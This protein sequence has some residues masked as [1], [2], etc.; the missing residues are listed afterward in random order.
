MALQEP[1]FLILTS[2]A[3][4]RKHGYALI[5]DAE[6]PRAARRFFA[7]LRSKRA[8]AIF[9]KHGFDVRN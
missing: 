3:E 5:K 7:H 1:T 4:G 9:K 6:E 2:L 8:L